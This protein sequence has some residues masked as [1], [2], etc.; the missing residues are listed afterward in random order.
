MISL[1]I[2]QSDEG[3][4]N[5]DIGWVEH[6]TDATSFTESEKNKFNL[7]MGENVRWISVKEILELQADIDLYYE[8]IDEK[9]QIISELEKELLG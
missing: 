9:K 5:G 2:I 7:P 8:L 3:F 1:F 6:T 4:W